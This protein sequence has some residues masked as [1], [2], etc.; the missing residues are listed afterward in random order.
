[1]DYKALNLGEKPEKIESVGVVLRPS[2]PELKDYF[3][4]VKDAFET[5]GIACHIDAVS[6][7]MIGVFGKEFERMCKEVDVLVTIGGDGT[8]ISTARRSFSYLKPIVG[9]N[10]G[11]LGFL[12]DV[13][14]DDVENFVSRLMKGD[15][16][17]DNR[18][19][20]ESTITTR[21]SIKT[22]YAFND[23]VITRKHI[24][25]M[26]HV[27]ASIEKE[28]FNTYYGD[29]LIISTPTG[30]TAYNISAGGP[31]VYP[32]SQIIV[33]TPICPHSLTQRPLV[34]PAELEI[35]LEV[36]DGEVAAIVFDGQEMEELGP[37]GVL[38]ITIAKKYAKLIHRKER[39]YFHVLR[40][41][42]RWGDL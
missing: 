38:S 9:I 25:K 11:N 8:L 31:V 18:I 22:I 32:Y 41:K 4:R 24:S 3:F 36:S 13:H 26:V 1:M 20:I 42:F 14:K 19:M 6:G 15:Y 17:V 23:V 21:D 10:M 28:P 29:G 2:T 7:G 27:K 33:I 37:K 35:E 5:K 39:N 16:R 12:T 34:L 30:S 40:E